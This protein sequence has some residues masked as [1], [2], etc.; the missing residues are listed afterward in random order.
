VA[1]AVVGMVHSHLVYQ[2]VRVEVLVMVRLVDQV[3]QEFQ[4]KDFPEE[5]DLFIIIVQLLL[6]VEAAV[7]E[8]L[9]VTTVEVVEAEEADQCL[10]Q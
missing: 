8:V 4:G 10:Q 2:E 3:D 5:T 1:E 9:V 6:Q 7:R